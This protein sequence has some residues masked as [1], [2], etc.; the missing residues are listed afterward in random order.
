MQNVPPNEQCKMQNPYL[1]EK[2]DRDPRREGAREA[3]RRASS[4]AAEQARG[5]TV[6]RRRQVS[7]G[8]RVPRERGR[9]AS[10]EQERRG[11]RARRRAT[12][13]GEGGGGGLGAWRRTAVVGGYQQPAL[14]LSLKAWEA[15]WA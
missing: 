3:G 12:G 14:H 2:G 11:S 8:T 13:D 6:G 5:P 7:Q 10:T 4:A 1:R 9:L 15:R